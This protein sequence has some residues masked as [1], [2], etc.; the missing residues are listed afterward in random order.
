MVAVPMTDE[1]FARIRARVSF[2][3]EAGCSALDGVGGLVDVTFSD[4]A[5]IID[6]DSCPETM[7]CLREDLLSSD[8]G[9]IVR[10]WDATTVEVLE[11]SDCCLARMVVTCDGQVWWAGEPGCGD[12]ST[13]EFP[14][15]AMRSEVTP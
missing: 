1:L 11:T 15:A 6:E 3:E 4:R 14:V 12:D 2:V 8:V 9:W 7:C 10:D 5:T 13:P